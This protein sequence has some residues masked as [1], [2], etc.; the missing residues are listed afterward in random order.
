MDYEED[1]THEPLMDNSQQ[2]DP[3]TFDQM[4]QIATEIEYKPDLKDRY[5]GDIDPPTK[6]RH[7]YGTYSY[8]NKFFQYQGFWNDG[9]KSTDPG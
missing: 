4:M 3:L 2:M 9:K 8:P 7:G 5:V 1:V 6:L